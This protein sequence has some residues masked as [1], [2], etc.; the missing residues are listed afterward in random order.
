MLELGL[1]LEPIYD[2]FVFHLFS[3]SMR[4]GRG[5]FGILARYL[6]TV[7]TKLA[8]VFLEQVLCWDAPRRCAP[9]AGVSFFCK[10][11]LYSQL[12]AKVLSGHF[13]Q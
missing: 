4:S 8:P 9:Q 5:K 1:P 11:Y 10:P 13:H 2:P 3:Y 6:L 7:N 12:P